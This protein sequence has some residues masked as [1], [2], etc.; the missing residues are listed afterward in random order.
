M[1]LPH[2]YSGARCIRSMFVADSAEPSDDLVFPISI[3]RPVG[4]GAA[5]DARDVRIIQ[6][7]LNRFPASMGGPVPR[8]KVDGIVGKF[9][10]GAI[11]KFQRRQ[12]GFTDFK[13]EPNRATIN[14][15][16]ELETAVWVTVNPRTMNRVQELLPLVRNCVLAADATM[17]LARP[18]LIAPSFR[19]PPAVQ[20]LAMI[21]RHFLLQRTSN[22]ERDFEL[23]RGV[24]RNM[25]ALLNRNSGGFERTFVPAPGRFNFART[26]V[27]GV[28]ATSFSDGKS[29]RGSLTAKAQDGSTV[30]IPLDKILIQVPFAFTT[31]DGQIITLIHEMAHYVGGA[32]DSA[33]SIDDP[34]NGNSSPEEIAKLSP[35]RRPHIA[36]NYATFAFEAFF[37]RPPIRMRF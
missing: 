25:L 36:E 13:I 14:K 2:C 15:I 16:N 3:T 8:L 19:Q 21:D 27:S 23:I 7:A 24:L 1:G 11:E 29:L 5:N 31:R 32:E 9:T 37:R 6:Q 33:E 20:A 34:P 18:A 28:L 35:D 12:L 22:H 17:L 30:E 10:T 4:P 26:I